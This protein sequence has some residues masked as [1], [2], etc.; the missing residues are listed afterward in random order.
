MN[1]NR[2]GMWAAAVLA[3]LAGVAGC[4]GAQSSGYGPG[5]GPGMGRMME[6]GPH[7]AAG[8]SLM[9]PDERRAHHDKMMSFKSL[10]ECKAYMAQHN[11]QMAERAKEKGVAH[12]GPREDACDV[13]QSRGWFK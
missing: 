13:M 1:A 10:D 4:A 3:V 2:K 7:N 6:F 9:T 11:K 5:H 12:A 8:W